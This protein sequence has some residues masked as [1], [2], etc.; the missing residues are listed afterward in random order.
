MAK[1]AR[2]WARP[3]KFALTPTA[4]GVAKAFQFHY[5]TSPTGAL[6]GRSFVTQTE[7][8]INALGTYVYSGVTNADEALR[9]AQQAVSTANTASNNASNALT[10][11]QSAQ[12]Q[13]TTLTNT[14][15]SWDAQIKNA[16]STANAASSTANTASQNASQA[17]ETANAASQTATEAVR[18]ANDAVTDTSAAE[19]RIN[20][21][22]TNAENSA[23]QAAS[24]A[25]E[26]ADNAQLSKRWAT[27][28]ENSAEEGQPDDYTVDGSEYSSK[29]Y[30]NLAKTS[31][32]N[33]ASSASAASKSA[34]A[35]ATSEKNAKTSETNAASSAS[36]ASASQT[37]AASSASAAK[38]SE[39]NA[40]S[41]ASTAATSASA[42]KT[43]ETNA[44]AS[45]TA[46]ESA[47]TAAE[48]ARDRA[49]DAA[50]ANQN[51]VVFTEQTLTAEQQ[52]QART[53]IAAAGDAELQLKMDKAGGTFTGAVS[54]IE[55]TADANLATK[56]YVDDHTA[57]TTELAQS[58][59]QAFIE[60]NQ[61]NGL[62]AFELK[63]TPA[64]T[65]VN[66]TTYLGFVGEGDLTTVT[67]FGSAS[68]ASVGS[69]TTLTE[70]FLAPDG[71]L[72][73]SFEAQSYPSAQGLTLT[74]GTTTITLMKIEVVGQSAPYKIR[75]ST[76]IRA[77]ADTRL[78]TFLTA[79]SEQ[80]I[81]GQFMAQAWSYPEQVF[82]MTCGTG[83]SRYG[84]SNFAN[85]YLG[86][87]ATF[88]SLD[89]DRGGGE[90]IGDTQAIRIRTLGTNGTTA[91][92]LTMRTL[93]ASAAIAEGAAPLPPFTS[94]VVT[95][96][97]SNRTC[98]LPLSH[99]DEADASSGDLQLSFQ[100]AV[101]PAFFVAADNTKKIPC[102]VEYL[103]GSIPNLG[104]ERSV[105]INVTA[106]SWTSS[107]T[108]ALGDNTG[109]QSG[110]GS[111]SRTT[112]YG[113]RTISFLGSNEGSGVTRAVIN[114]ASTPYDRLVLTKTN[115]GE[116][117][118]LLKTHTTSS[119]TYFDS[120]IGSP[121]FFQTYEVGQAVPITLAYWE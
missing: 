4:D 43:S 15:N 121:A 98:V 3:V 56:K 75:F 116:E 59:L 90:V 104:T 36:A 106:A 31:E 40:A 26:A 27:W 49:E 69:S 97:D 17:V 45:E 57:E 19:A 12:S 8:A 23:T 38:T 100:D 66:N 84:Y 111:L 115:S 67:P 101:N 18:I 46:A 24:N 119:A 60:F 91:T 22:V 1:N 96:R 50:A 32:T 95:R 105:S 70:L 20:Q 102:T 34:T 62:S 68:Q 80:T 35:A 82:T 42:A 92:V 86:N 81:S 37:A 30:A 109:Y 39:T 61:E 88:G 6:N 10:T 51:A 85:T 117:I 33:A 21:A 11:A 83:N 113:N 110:H 47:K 16:V 44:K 87:S 103:V 13:V 2:T 63:V 99:I 108:P 71:L 53:N 64:S 54:G 14:V 5:V 73:A 52:A 93:A 72:Y 28:T 112:D 65:T 78:A 77:E 114:N 55:P 74:S 7:D 79:G 107:A 48:A 120:A 41:S 94:C 9:L 89:P 76:P 29:W 118:E 25:T 58:I